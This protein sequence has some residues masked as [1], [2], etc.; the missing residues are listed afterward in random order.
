MHVYEVV[1]TYRI[2]FIVIELYVRFL[3]GKKYRL[4]IKII[5]LHENNELRS[6]VVF[7]ILKVLIRSC[8]YNFFFL[9][10][11]PSIYARMHI[12]VHIF[13]LTNE[14][15]RTSQRTFNNFNVL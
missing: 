8:S 9:L 1:P 5:F 12:Y 10:N 7:V 2:I 4:K 6:R 13:V 11:E 3:E 14:I 15:G